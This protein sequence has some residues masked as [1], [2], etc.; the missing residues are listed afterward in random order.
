M[1]RAMAVIRGVGAGRRA[2]GVAIA[3]APFRSIRRSCR[4][5]KATALPRNGPGAVEIAADT[6]GHRAAEA[7]TAGLPVEAVDTAGLPVEVVDTAGL[8]VD[9]SGEAEADTRL[10]EVVVDTR[11]AAAVAATPAAAVGAKADSK[12]SSFSLHARRAATLPGHFF[13][14]AMAHLVPA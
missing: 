9:R 2:D 6:A 4:T 5:A 3:A 11:S 7:D 13:V 8:P 14:L 12:F 1:R 10:A